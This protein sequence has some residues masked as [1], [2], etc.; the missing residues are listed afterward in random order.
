MKFKLVA[1][2]AYGV[3]EYN[4]RLILDGQPSLFEKMDKFLRNTISR[5]NKSSYPDSG[6]SDADESINDIK[7]TRAI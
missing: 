1:L 3:Y 5:D 2:I 7:P 6:R 4:K